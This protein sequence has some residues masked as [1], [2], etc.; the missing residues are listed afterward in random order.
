MTVSTDTCRTEAVSSTV[1]AA[2]EPKLDHPSLALVHVSQRP[3]RI[4]ERDEVLATLI[5][6]GQRVIERHANGPAAALLI[7]L[8]SRDVDEDTPH[9]PRG[10][11]Q[12]V[13]P[14]LPVDVLK[15]DQSEVRLVHER[16]RVQ[17][18][19]GTFASHAASGDAP[20]LVVHERDQLVEGGLIA[21]AP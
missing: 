7:A 9:Q 5:R 20:Q 2:K 10:H 6:H 15:I 18:V 8:R 19:P 11:R 1:K 12:E 16:R 21:R 13:S 14:V 4:V 3:E 17:A